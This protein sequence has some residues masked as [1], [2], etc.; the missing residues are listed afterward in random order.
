M[1]ESAAEAS[2]SLVWFGL[3]F[4]DLRGVLEADVGSMFR[5]RVRNG[6]EVARRHCQR[7]M[8]LWLGPIAAAQRAFKEERRGMVCRRE[9]D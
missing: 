7:Y 4:G 1:H 8:H 9:M 5:G 2:D 3:G 6:V